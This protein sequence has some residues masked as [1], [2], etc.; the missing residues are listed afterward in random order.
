M[1][2]ESNSRKQTNVMCKDCSGNRIIASREEY[3]GTKNATRSVIWAHST[4]GKNPQTYIVR[5]SDAET[6]SYF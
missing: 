1:N 2:K 3:S 6:T 4:V 5:D